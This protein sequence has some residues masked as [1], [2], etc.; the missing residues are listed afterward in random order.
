LIDGKEALRQIE[1]RASTVRRGV[2]SREGTVAPVVGIDFGTTYTK[3]AVLDRGEVVLIEDEKSNSATRAATPSV[4]AVAKDGSVLIGEAARELLVVRPQRV[5]SSIKRVL[6]LRYSNPLANG[7]LGTLSC[8]SVQ[9]PNDSI[10]FDVEGKQFT[11]PE[12]VSRILAHVVDMASAWAGC[13]VTKAVLTHPVDF[14]VQAQRELELAARMAG[15]EILAL[16]PEPVAAVMGC[17]FGGE[18]DALV[19]V[20][21][22]GGGTFDASL[23]EVGAE[24]FNVLGSAG[25]RWLGGDDLDELLARHAADKFWLEKDI[26]LHNR[27][28][29]FQRL[30]FACEETKR[31]LSALDRVDVIM[32]N[33]G[34]TAE[35]QQVL[36]VPVDRSDFDA[37]AADVVASSLEVCNQATAE[38]GRDPKDIDAL[39]LTG[40]TA[41]VPVVRAG[42]ERF[43][44]R[45]GVTG[46]HPEHAV[47]IGAAV[48]A[49]VAVGE[50]VPDDVGARL[51]TQQA[52]GRSVS[53]VND[54][55]TVEPVFEV[56]QQPPLTAHRH[57]ATSMDNQTK[58]RLEL[59]EGTNEEA[60]ENRRIG[61]VVVDGLPARPA[62]D[63]ALNVYFELSSTGTLSVI[64]QD[65]L[66]GHRAQAT[67][68]LSSTE[69]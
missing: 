18:K 51:R 26:T 12:V 28:E 16:V 30:L 17:G 7:L 67:F 63:T 19:A 41:R 59:V 57:F 33:A 43:F 3:I 11:V 4:L 23:V 64:A 22:F 56:A 8:K 40:G 29:E 34:L 62:G 27:R 21:D 38:A 53:L 2:R 45:I 13:K 36:M 15:I 37:L 48:R 9:G 47:V 61:S 31:L 60:D 44:G 49:A 50:K 52:Q 42:A 58:I 5:I 14:D 66:S 68:D 69:S 25:D 54:D 65:R 55:G 20:Y 35:G 46:I 10:L 24:K 1:S 6:G 32:P 39:L